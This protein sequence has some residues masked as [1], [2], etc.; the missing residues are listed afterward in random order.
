MVY[1][2]THL[3]SLRPLRRTARTACY[4]R[5]T[6]LMALVLYLMPSNSQQVAVA[7]AETQSHRQLSMVTES[8]LPQK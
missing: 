8:P 5:H 4:T 1:P 7:V 6:V 3:D 2:R